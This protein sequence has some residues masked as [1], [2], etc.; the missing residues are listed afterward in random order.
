MPEPEEGDFKRRAI[1]S[2]AQ[3]L[4]VD[5]TFDDTQNE[6]PLSASTPSSTLPIGNATGT[7][8]STSPN[9]IHS[10]NNGS[11]SGANKF[12]TPFGIIN[13]DIYST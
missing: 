2:E 1:S 8:G 10:N 6:Y 5:I 9:S 7:G 3:L 13:N 12:N 4:C 11:N